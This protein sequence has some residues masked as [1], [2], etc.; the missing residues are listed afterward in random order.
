VA[1]AWFLLV[2]Q[3]LL[4]VELLHDSFWRPRPGVLFL[5]YLLYFP[6]GWPGPLLPGEHCVVAGTGDSLDFFVV[7]L[8]GLVEALLSVCLCRL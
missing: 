5:L 7:F 6:L 4:R 1:V 2:Q 3:P 8:W